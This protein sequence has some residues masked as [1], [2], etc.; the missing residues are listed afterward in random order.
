MVFPPDHNCR[1]RVDSI[2]WRARGCHFEL[3][4]KLAAEGAHHCWRVARKYQNG[5]RNP[6]GWL[7]RPPQTRAAHFKPFYRN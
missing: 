4:L 2:R 5:I 1:D 3:L 6:Y 7:P